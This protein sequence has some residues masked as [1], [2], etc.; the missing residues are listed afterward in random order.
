MTGD[1][2]AAVGALP[3]TGHVAAFAPTFR[4]LRAPIELPTLLRDLTPGVDL[5]RLATLLAL[6]D[7]NAAHDLASRSALAR[8][9]QPEG[10]GAGWA[11]VAF[12]APA[13]PSRF[14][15][16]NRGVW[17][18]GL[19]LETAIAETAY[20]LERQLRQFR[21]PPQ[22]VPLQV[23]GAEIAGAFVD[24]RTLAS[25]AYAAVH[26][27]ADYTAAHQVGAVVWRRGD[28]GVVYDSVRHPAGTCVAAFRPRVVHYPRPTHRVEHR[29]TGS[30][31]RLAVPRRIAAGDRG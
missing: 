24:L 4:A 25:G 18:A 19:A 21:E 5:D 12:T 23:L 9:D 8:A 28:D 1:V 31:L 16:G 29:W 22:D 15:D 7:P 13:R 6:T 2:A 3:S 14:T 27:P 17:Y 20:H 30:E 10:P 11:L 26:D